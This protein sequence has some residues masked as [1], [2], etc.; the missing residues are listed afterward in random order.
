MKPVSFKTNTT[1][2]TIFT[3]FEHTEKRVMIQ[4]YE[5]GKP[6]WSTYGKEEALSNIQT[7][8]WHEVKER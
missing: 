5:G 6:H 3:M 7:K 1:G 8:W 2:I 4:R